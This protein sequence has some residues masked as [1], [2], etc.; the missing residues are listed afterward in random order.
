[1][2]IEQ[3][4]ELFDLRV[5]GRDIVEAIK[6]IKHLQKN[7]DVYMVSENP[8]IREEYD[9]I[10]LQLATLLRSLTLVRE[11]GDDSAAILSLDSLKSDMDEMESQIISTVGT[12]IREEKIPT[13]MA[14]SLMNDSSYAYNVSSKLIEMGEALFS[15][16]SSDIKDAE[17][18]IALDDDEIEAVMLSSQSK[19]N[20]TNT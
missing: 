12:L 15:S 14:T 18:S 1:M 10:R 7:L 20:I 2:T 6:D 8:Q 9:A 17:R 19:A 5:A 16:G 11:Q 13:E 4:E 3:T